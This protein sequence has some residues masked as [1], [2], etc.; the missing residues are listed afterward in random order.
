MV[1]GGRH[2]S[3]EP[4]AL[5]RGVTAMKCPSCGWDEGNSAERT[6]NEFMGPSTKPIAAWELEPLFSTKWEREDYERRKRGEKPLGPTQGR[7]APHTELV[8][9]MRK[10]LPVSAE[11]VL[12]L[13]AADAIERL[14]AHGNELMMQL[15]FVEAW[16]LSA[17]ADLAAKDA[18]I[19]R[20]N[21][22]CQHNRDAFDAQEKEIARLRE[23]LEKIIEQER[24]FC[25]G[26]DGCYA[27]IAIAHA[28]AALGTNP[29]PLA[30]TPT[31]PPR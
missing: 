27:G 3:L 10:F 9:K 8:R 31:D 22:L 19:D 16:N 30:G 29:H 26:P 5:V 14:A 18:E 15:E 24:D 2:Y 1:Y 13:E 25:C 17:R 28:R 12:M 7:D 4:S 23:A 11:N 6:M 20:W 21:D